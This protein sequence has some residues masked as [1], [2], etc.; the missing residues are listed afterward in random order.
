MTDKAGICHT[1]QQRNLTSH[2]QNQ[3]NIKKKIENHVLRHTSSVSQ[4]GYQQIKITMIEMQLLHYLPTYRVK[5][6]SRSS[7]PIIRSTPYIFRTHG[8][9]LDCATLLWEIG[10]RKIPL[11]VNVSSDIYCRMVFGIGDCRSSGNVGMFAYSE[12]SSRKVRKRLGS[13]FGRNLR[14]DT[15]HYVT[16]KDSLPY[17][18]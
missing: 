12:E 17:G 15:R 4:P 8:W 1:H 5:G 14:P 9:Y 16:P 2:Q 18:R 7:L 3:L 6:S 10:F 13:L 11:W